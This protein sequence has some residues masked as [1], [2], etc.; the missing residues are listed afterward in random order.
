[1]KARATSNGDA[2]VGVCVKHFTERAVGRCEDCGELWC[3]ECLVPPTRR[4][5]PTRCIGC[6]LVVAGIRAPG[7]RRPGIT[8]V[9]RFQRRPNRMI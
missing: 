7:P 4:S 8:N 3:S 5:R 1:M 2:F 6:A 9:G